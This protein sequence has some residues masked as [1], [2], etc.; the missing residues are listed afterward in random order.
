MDADA[1]SESQSTEPAGENVEVEGVVETEAPADGGSVE[2]E[3]ATAEP[4]VFDVSGYQDHLVTVKVDGEEQQVPMSEALNGYQRQADYT[5]KTQQAATAM[6]LQTAIE[7]DPE[8]SLRMLAAKFGVDFGSSPAG[9]QPAEPAVSAPSVAADPIADSYVNDPRIAAMWQEHND[10]ILDGVLDG[11]SSKYGELY[12][13]QELLSAAQQRGIES[14]YELEQVF[15]SLTYD[16]MYAQL[17]AQQQAAS[18]ASADDAAREQAVANAQQL[19]SS[20]NG[21]APG[22][23]T[24]SPP[25]IN[26]VEDAFTA[27]KQQLGIV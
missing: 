7:S 19:V 9:T 16:K 21:V 14:P 6:A 13:E 17:T 15:Q 20:G 4:A 27:A 22:A 8:T 26:S 2:V 24:P 23:P 11:L 1:F 25:V 5:R 10:R 3:A 18:T 12:N